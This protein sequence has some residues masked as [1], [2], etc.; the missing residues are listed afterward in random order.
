MADLRRPVLGAPDPQ[1][2]QSERGLE[3]QRSSGELAGGSTR[4]RP[5]AVGGEQALWGNAALNAAQAHR[6]ENE[7]TSLAPISGA[8]LNGEMTTSIFA[9]ILFCGLNLF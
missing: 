6:C 4:H 8:T 7:V 9:C 5:E 1:A 2:G 3:G